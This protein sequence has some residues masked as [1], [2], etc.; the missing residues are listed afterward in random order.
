MDISSTIVLLGKERVKEIIR[1]HGADRILFG[2]DSPYRSPYSE[3]ERFLKLGL[4]E[5]EKELIL[6]GNAAKLLEI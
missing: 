5:S 4:P 3:L 1:K 2:T 6:Y